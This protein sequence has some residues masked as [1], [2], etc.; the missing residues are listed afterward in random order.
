M[1]WRYSVCSEQ[2]NS[3]HSLRHFLLKILNFRGEA[4]V[5]LNRSIDPICNM[6]RIIFVFIVLD[7]CYGRFYYLLRRLFWLHVTEPRG[8]D[9]YTWDMYTEKKFQSK[10][11]WPSI[12]LAFSF[13]CLF[14]I[15][16]YSKIW[17]IIFGLNLQS[18]V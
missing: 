2:C 15:L 6:Y 14:Y 13:S 17:H 8:E 16:E 10:L 7:V 4:R 11:P 1:K 18:E 5:P 12:L 3:K 9:W